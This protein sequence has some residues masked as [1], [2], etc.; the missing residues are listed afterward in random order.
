MNHVGGNEPFW[1]S[2]PISV[3]LNQID[4]N[5]DELFMI[6]D[7]YY[8]QAHYE[9]IMSAKDDDVLRLNNLLSTGQSITGAAK[10][11]NVSHSIA[12]RLKKKNHQSIYSQG[13]LYLIKSVPGERTVTLDVAS[14]TLSHKFQLRVRHA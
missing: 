5:L 2:S 3:A 1:L 11:V 4:S 9:T 14:G 6:D 12:Q 13:E 8:M 7:V 10:I